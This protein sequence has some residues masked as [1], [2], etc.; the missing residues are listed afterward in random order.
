VLLARLLHGIGASPDARAPQ[1]SSPVAAS[2]RRLQRPSRLSTFYRYDRLLASHFGDEGCDRYLG[3]PPPYPP[4]GLVAAGGFKNVSLV[5]TPA[6]KIRLFGSL[7]LGGGSAY[8]MRGSTALF[9]VAALAATAAGKPPQPVAPEKPKPFFDPDHALPYAILFCGPKALPKVHAN[10]R[11]SLCPV[12]A[13]ASEDAG[14]FKRG[15]LGLERLLVTI[16]QVREALVPGS[17]ELAHGRS[18]SVST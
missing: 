3:G 1:P 17:G 15:L 10:A 4:R 5:F 13:A 2:T 14:L 11:P 16:T 18:N 6:A 8:P 12:R 7:A 9:F